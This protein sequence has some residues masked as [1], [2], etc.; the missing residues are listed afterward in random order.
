MYSLLS[1]LDRLAMHSYLSPALVGIWKN[2][3]FRPTHY[4]LHSCS[5]NTS[6]RLISQA[7][8]KVSERKHRFKP[9][10]QNL[11]R[12]IKLD[13]FFFLTSHRP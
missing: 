3:A 6:R 8:G 2:M 12:T 13:I 10:T 1:K 11:I 7:R 4:F 9:L 5:S